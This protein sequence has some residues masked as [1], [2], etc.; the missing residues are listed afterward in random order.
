MKYLSKGPRE[1]FGPF[2]LSKRTIYIVGYIKIPKQFSL[3]KR[4]KPR[5]GK[6]LKMA[7]FCAR[8]YGQRRVGPSFLKNG[9]GA[10]RL[11]LSHIGFH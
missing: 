3:I 8:P 11:L 7:G 9:G 6:T 10:I 5:L 1:H 2:Y 4:L